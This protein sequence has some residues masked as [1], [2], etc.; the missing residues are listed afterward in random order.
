MRGKARA[1]GAARGEG[2][3]AGGF[4]A[5]DAKLHHRER[6][7]GEDEAFPRA[8]LEIDH[9]VDPLAG[10]EDEIA[11]GEGSGKQALVGAD[12]VKRQSVG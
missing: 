5:A 9:D 4:D 2:S 12:L 1:Y 7:V 11:E 6:I 10:G 8:I 3:G